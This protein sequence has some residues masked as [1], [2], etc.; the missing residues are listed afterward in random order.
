MELANEQGDL[1]GIQSM[2]PN[3]FR[4]I[5]F[6]AG[7]R[8]FQSDA[9]TNTDVAWSSNSQQTQRIYQ[10]PSKNYATM[11]TS[12]KLLTSKTET[13][14]SNVEG[15]V[16]ELEFAYK[17]TK[18]YEKLTMLKV[19]AEGILKIRTDTA[20][21]LKNLNMLHIDQFQGSIKLISE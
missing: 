14:S 9:L 12:I 10:P 11:Y 21:A 4:L 8:H 3:I 2:D 13:N 17:G 16:A 7:D 6:E 19:K 5:A 18:T 15:T 1:T 20:D